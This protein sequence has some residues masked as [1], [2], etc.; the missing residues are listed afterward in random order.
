[1]DTAQQRNGEKI[2][3]FQIE[4]SKKKY[5]HAYS[6]IHTQLDVCTVHSW[7]RF[8]KQ[9]KFIVHDLNYLER[10]PKHC[11]YRILYALNKMAYKTKI[12]VIAFVLKYTQIQL[13]IQYIMVMLLT[14][15]KKKRA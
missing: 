1:M 14:E 13:I 9:R 2:V 10:K 6:F 7:I 4:T 11:Y 3:I 12:S 8:L 5:T 15:D